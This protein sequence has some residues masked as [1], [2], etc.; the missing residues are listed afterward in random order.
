MPDISW[1]PIVVGNDAVGI[2]SVRKGVR[3]CLGG[4]E[5]HASSR[6][7]PHCTIFPVVIFAG[8]LFGTSPVAF[9]RSRW[10]PGGSF[11]FNLQV[12]RFEFFQD[13]A[14]DIES[15]STAA[16]KTCD[17]ALSNLPVET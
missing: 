4:I 9:T 15:V 7:L 6:S 13:V 17:S 14:D 8:N 1:P 16:Q 5:R 12:V 2:G 10:R 3:E 11:G